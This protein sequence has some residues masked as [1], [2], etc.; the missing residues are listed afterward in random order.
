[1]ILVAG[2]CQLLGCWIRW[3]LCEDFGGIND[4]PGFWI[5][6]MEGDW[7]KLIDNLS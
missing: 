1:M 6:C 5:K 2:E 4:T 7:H 3:H